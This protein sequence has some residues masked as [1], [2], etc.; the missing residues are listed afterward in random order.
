MPRWTNRGLDGGGETVRDK[1][2]PGENCRGEGRSSK[3]QE[4]L[5]SRKISPGQPGLSPAGSAFRAYLRFRR[6]FDG[7]ESKL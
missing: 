2:V 4:D 7:S 1:G 5:R 3:V 6:A